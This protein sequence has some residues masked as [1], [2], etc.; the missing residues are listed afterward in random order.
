MLC[1]VV[2]Q[3][4]LSY[5]FGWEKGHIPYTSKRSVSSKGVCCYFEH[6]RFI[7]YFK[8][9]FKYKLLFSTAFQA[10]ITKIKRNVSADFQINKRTRICSLHFKPSDFTTTITG[11]RNVSYSVEVCVVSRISQAKITSQETMAFPTKKTKFSCQ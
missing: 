5:T 4:R 2:Q 7:S 10:W 9:C 6:L 1:T 11:R 8:C 3:N